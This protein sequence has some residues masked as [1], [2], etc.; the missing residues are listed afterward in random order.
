MSL[1]GKWSEVGQWRL[2]DLDKSRQ[3]REGGKGEGSEGER[4]GKGLLGDHNFCTG[5]FN[6][7]SFDSCSNVA[8]LLS[9]SNF[10]AVSKISLANS[11]TCTC[12]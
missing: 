8:R 4:E 7:G 2:H 12:T 3:E 5:H 10:R 11:L 9:F 6:A 1:R